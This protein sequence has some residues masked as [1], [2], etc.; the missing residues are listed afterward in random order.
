MKELVNQRANSNVFQER[1][2]AGGAA[3][4]TGAP[5]PRKQARRLLPGSYQ[6]GR[7]K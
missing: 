1:G 6:R 4:M 5:A 7:D 3:A 2:R